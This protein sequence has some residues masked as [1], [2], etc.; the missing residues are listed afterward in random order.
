VEELPKLSQKYNWVSVFGPPCRFA[1]AMLS[2][3][4]FFGP[5]F[6]RWRAI[7]WDI[8]KCWWSVWTW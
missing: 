3:K 6:V 5:T 8:D 2:N 7:C 4:R 1:T